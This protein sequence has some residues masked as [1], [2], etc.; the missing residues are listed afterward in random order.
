MTRPSDRL[1]EGLENWHASQY[2]RQIRAGS[3]L[4]PLPL[5]AQ[6]SPRGMSQDTQ[7]D[8]DE[9]LN[10]LLDTARRIEALPT[11]RPSAPFSQRLGRQVQAR[12][13][14]MRTTSKSRPLA[15]AER[16]PRRGFALSGWMRVHPGLAAVVVLL[17]VMGIVGVAGAQASDPG[18]PLYQV[19]RFEQS[20]QL[21]F[22]SPADRVRLHIGNARSDLQALS[23]Y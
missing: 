8:Q 5:E 23:S 7:T 17:A 6:S 21:S 15:R 4:A 10:A 13:A 1:D 20:I 12:A 16:R 19:K 3:R 14:A 2:D 18:S 22:A 9:T 11:F